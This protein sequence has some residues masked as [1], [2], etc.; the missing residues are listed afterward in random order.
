MNALAAGQSPSS[1]VLSITDL[2]IALRGRNIRPLVENVSFHVE[3]AETVA[4]IGESGSGKTITALAVLGLLPKSLVTTTS[5]VSDKPTTRIALNGTDLLSLSSATLAQIRG[6]EISAIFQDPMNS[7]NPTMRIGNQIAEARRVHF[8]ENRKV[9]HRYAID[10]L[11][12]VGIDRPAERFKQFPHELSGGMQQR[13][14]IAMAI[15]CEPKLLIA[16]EPTTALDVTVQRQILQLLKEIQQDSGLSILFVTHDLGVVR[17]IADRVAVLHAGQLVED[18]HVGQVL[19]AP[20]HPYTAAL[21][22]AMPKLEVAREILPII[23]G[24][25]P[26]PTDFPPGCR[27]GPRCQFFQSQCAEEPLETFLIGDRHRTLCKRVGE[28]ELSEVWP[29]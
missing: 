16:D 18:G 6:R 2:S 23:R 5:S 15:A 29:S 10:L 20:A 24:R 4:L 27:Y 28:G 14:M 21:I 7:L 22:S 12:R 17:H 26:S 11:E 13:V 8:G 9:A 1:A 25:V 19:A 3:A